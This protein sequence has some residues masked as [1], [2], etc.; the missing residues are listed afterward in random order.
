[1]HF[2]KVGAA[3]TRLTQ[4]Y[5]SQAITPDP[6]PDRFIVL[7]LNINTV[8]PF[9]TCKVTVTLYLKSSACY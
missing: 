3:R 9:Y 7:R 2:T 4:G 5:L 8:K 6:K 1:M